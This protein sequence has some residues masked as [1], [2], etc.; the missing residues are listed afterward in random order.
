M[1]P[2]LT[3]SL[4]IDVVGC[5]RVR[6]PTIQ[7][8]LPTSG[9]NALS[10]ATPAGL[11]I[12]LATQQGTR[13]VPC[14][15]V[16]RTREDFFFAYYCMHSDC[17]AWLL[18]ESCSACCA[19][20]PRGSTKSGRTQPWNARAPMFT[21]HDVFDNGCSLQRLQSTR[22]ILDLPGR[23]RLA[24]FTRIRMAL[25]RRT[26]GLQIGNLQRVAVVWECQ[27]S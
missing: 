16:F 6:R 17:I 7:S 27:Q 10:H 3:H 21:M 8:S 12:S 15:E 13:Q 18:V 9:P 19:L 14:M 4:S 1:S 23:R 22:S 11:S 25:V 2:S 5:I 26:T 20:L 24:W